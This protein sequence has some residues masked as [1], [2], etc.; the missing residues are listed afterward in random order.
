[1]DEEIR[2][3]M[4]RLEER[5]SN[6]ME[7]TTEYRKTLCHKIDVIQEEL[8]ELPC[9]ERRGKYESLSVQVKAIWLFVVGIIL[10]IISEYFKLK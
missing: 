6:W 2:D 5:V 3:R 10:S 4:A 8:R 9:P 1:M 7:T